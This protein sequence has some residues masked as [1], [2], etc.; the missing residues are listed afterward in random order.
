LRCW[1]NIR[2]GKRITGEPRYLCSDDG[3]TL[4]GA[5][6]RIHFPA[7]AFTSEAATIEIG[8]PE[9]EQVVDFD[10]ASRR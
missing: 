1:F 5:T 10:L 9:G 4:S 7:S 6:A 8:L 2:V 3:C